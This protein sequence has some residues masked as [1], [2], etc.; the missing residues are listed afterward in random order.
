MGTSDFNML[1][2][3]H[4]SMLAHTSNMTPHEHDAHDAPQI[5]TQQELTA[6]QRFIGSC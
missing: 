3:T 2:H 1:T 5:P 4:F 6:Y